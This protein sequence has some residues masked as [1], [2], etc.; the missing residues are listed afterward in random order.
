M[1]MSTL[2]TVGAYVTAWNNRELENLMAL[3]TENAVMSSPMGPQ[4]GKA[5]IRSQS[6]MFLAMTAKNKMTDPYE[7]NGAVRA[8]IKAPVGTVTLTFTVAGG[9]IDR[10]D[11]KMGLR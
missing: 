1:H 6:S 5:Q 3:F 10:I 11:A 7:E 2:E 8:K 4:K 9:L